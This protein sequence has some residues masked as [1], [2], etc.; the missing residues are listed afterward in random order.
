[1]RER[2]EWRRLAVA[3][4]TKDEAK[5]FLRRIGLDP[6]LAGKARLLGGLFD[7]LAGAIELPAV[8]DAA[9][10]VVFD[11][12][13]M[14]R[15]AAVRAPIGDDLRCRMPRGRARSPRS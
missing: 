15:R 5:I 1:M 6:D 11:P 14:H 7:A 10:A 3:E 2:R 12:A 9:D 4:I 13:E 8:I